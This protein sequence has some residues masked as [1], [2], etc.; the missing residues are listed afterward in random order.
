MVKLD[1]RD[2]AV[3]VCLCAGLVQLGCGGS[4]TAESANLAVTAIDSSDSGSPARAI[5]LQQTFAQA[6]T[7]D[8]PGNQLPP[9]DQTKAGLATAMLRLKVQQLW[10]SIAFRT[11]D[12]KPIQYTALLETEFGP[13]TIGL[14][15]DLAPNHVRNFVALARAGYYNGLTVDRVI[16][17]QSDDP[18][19]PALELVE[20]GCP[21]GSGEPGIGHLGYWLYP[22]FSETAKHELG[23]VGACRDD[24]P[25][26]AASRFYITLAPAPAMDGNFTVFGRVVHGLDVVRTISKQPRAAGLVQPDKPVVIRKVTIQT[27]EVR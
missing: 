1:K 3:I 7:E 19:S 4:K 17:Q 27:Q 26:S 24:E 22:E 15:P 18:A 14:R 16:E 8:S 10:D 21:A 25:V 20:C 9:P 12:G 13:V 11:S 6:V 2:G 23:T 5:D